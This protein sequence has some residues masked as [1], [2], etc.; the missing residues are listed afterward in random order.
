MP[1]RFEI[2]DPSGAAVPDS[3][4][5]GATEQG[6]GN[7]AFTI[8][9]ELAGGEYVLTVRSMDDAF[10]EE[11]RPFFISRYRLP[12]LKK[13]LEFARDSYGPGDAVV[14]DFLARR[15]EGG[16]AAGA[17]LHVT[18]TVDGQTVFEDAKAQADPTGTL[19]VKFT[20]P[21]KIDR[22]D[23]QLVVLVDDGGTQEPI[24]KTIPIN[25]GKVEVKFYPE[26]GDLVDGLENRVYFTSRDPLG[27]PVHIEGTI[28]NAKGIAVAR[29][30]TTHEGMGSFSFLP[31]QGE[32]YRLKI[33]SPA[34][35]NRAVRAARGR[36]GA[37]DRA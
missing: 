17:Q 35:T 34:G 10:P 12:R 22:G 29:V 28:V 24:V 9:A 21:E 33:T 4:Q 31:R 15:A 25:L 16:P 20:L 32:P 19:Q 18:A 36:G 3:Q 13:E 30:E 26:G 1:I 5:E 37:E 6:V 14:A 7:G 11:K 27:E 23:G 2:L 8:P